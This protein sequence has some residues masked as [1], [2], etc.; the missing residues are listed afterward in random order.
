MNTQTWET[1][2]KMYGGGR[3][4]KYFTDE[5]ISDEEIIAFLSAT[6]LAPSG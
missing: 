1:F 4:V 3:A 5:H 6:Q 2:E